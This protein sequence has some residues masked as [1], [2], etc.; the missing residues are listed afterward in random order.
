MKFKLPIFKRKKKADT[1]LKAVFSIFWDATMRHGYI[2]RKISNSKI[3]M[4]SPSAPYGTIEIKSRHIEV[5]LHNRVLSGRVRDSAQRM[6]RVE[7]SYSKLQPHLAY[8]W[9]NECIVEHKKFKK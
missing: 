5:R 8:T 3:M 4:V 6:S 1:E 9:L 7:F 2:A